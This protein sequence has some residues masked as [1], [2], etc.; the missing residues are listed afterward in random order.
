[1]R[2]HELYAVIGHRD[3]ENDL[4]RQLREGCDPTWYDEE[5]A[6]RLEDLYQNLFTTNWEA[7]PCTLDWFIIGVFTAV[8]CGLLRYLMFDKWVQ[9]CDFEDFRYVS[10]LRQS[11]IT[12]IVV[13]DHNVLRVRFEYRARGIVPLPEEA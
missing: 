10:A 5:I 8:L 6:Q 9:H 11:I 3:S 1:V 12:T 4:F 7:R 13:A 2:S